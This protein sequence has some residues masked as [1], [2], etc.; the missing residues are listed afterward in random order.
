MRYLVL[1]MSLITLFEV[2]TITFDCFDTGNTTGA[3]FWGLLSLV[4]IALTT[5]AGSLF[6]N[7]EKIE[8]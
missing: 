6:D 4:L 1:F 8:K 2:V 5:Y 3:A 7:K